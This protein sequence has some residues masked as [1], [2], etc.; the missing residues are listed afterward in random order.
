MLANP[1]PEIAPTILENPVGPNARQPR[2]LSVTAARRGCLHAASTL[3]V[4]TTA[5]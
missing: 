3:T 5:N 4:S 2:A 1:Y